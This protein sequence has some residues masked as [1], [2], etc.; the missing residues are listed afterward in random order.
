[1]VQLAGND[2]LET[3]PGL[4]IQEPLNLLLRPLD[5][6]DQ[7]ACSAVEEAFTNPDHRAGSEKVSNKPGKSCS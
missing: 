6:S 5:V 2:L 1:M 3:A 7:E 4:K